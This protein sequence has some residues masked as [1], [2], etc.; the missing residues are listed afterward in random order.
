MRTTTDLMA[1]E[2]LKAI[3]DRLRKQYGAERVL[4]YGS[5][6]RGEQTEHSD[7]DL[8]KARQILTLAL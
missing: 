6:A 3:A 1:Q 4:V 2:T 5:V 8:T 7:I